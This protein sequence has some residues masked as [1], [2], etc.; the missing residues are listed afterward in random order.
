MLPQDLDTTVPPAVDGDKLDVI[1]ADKPKETGH[2]V[3]ASNPVIGSEGLNILQKL[4][5]FGIIVGVV[6]IY[7][8]ARRRGT[9]PLEKFP[10]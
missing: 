10:A 5:F 6:A 1:E 2:I 8:R 3:L 9:G 4:T 7:F